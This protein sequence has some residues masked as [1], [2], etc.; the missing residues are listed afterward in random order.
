MSS[1]R[2]VIKGR[3]AYRGKY[4][5]YARMAPKAKPTSDGFVWLSDQRKAERWDDPRHRG[6][7]WSTALARRH[8][9]YFVKLV[10]PKEVVARV[11]E[12]RAY[13]AEHASGASV[14]YPCYWFN[15]TLRDYGA[16]FC[17]DC[18]ET[19][20]D[21]EYDADPKG[22]KKL[23]GELEGVNERYAAAIHGGIDIHHDS[24]PSCATCGV[25]LSGHL[26]N[27]GADKQLEYIQL[28]DWTPPSDSAEAWFALG[29]AVVNI[30]DD[31]PRWKRIANVVDRACEAERKAA[32]SSAE[33][34]ATP[35]MTEVRL[36]LLIHLQIRAIQKAPD[37]SFRLWDE[38]QA[39]L[40]IPYDERMATKEVRELHRRLRCEAKAFAA[41]LGYEWRDDR[42]KAP[43]GEYAWH[44]IVKAEQYKLWSP[45]AYQEGR[46]YALHPCPSGNPARPHHRDA[47]PY[48][49]VVG[50]E[51]SEQWDVGFILGC[52]ESGH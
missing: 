46:A 14:A 7:T 35:G 13:I 42:I 15:N 12:M 25:K 39:F 29:K 44:F 51:R 27:Y 30:S 31:D 45:P 43:Y 6:Q 4:L 9:G 5:G 1:E 36:A 34:A 18:A 28:V 38:L 24:P 40:A 16:N 32:A 20:V 11:R 10:A 19:I 23:Y 50:E 47:N 22:F 17:Q 26:T 2:H 8:N 48:E 33:L 49:K 21:E 3:G 52:H 37:P 41:C